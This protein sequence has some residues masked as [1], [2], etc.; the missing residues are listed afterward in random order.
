MHSRW[1]I[2]WRSQISRLNQSQTKHIKTKTK[3][4]TKSVMWPMAYSDIFC[5]KMHKHMLENKNKFLVV[6]VSHKSQ[7]CSKKA[8]GLQ[9]RLK[10]PQKPIS[11]PR[12]HNTIWHNI[13]VNNKG[14]VIFPP[15][16]PHF[17]IDVQFCIWGRFKTFLYS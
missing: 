2:L 16:A 4:I 11:A 15:W 3:N 6:S 14:P 7:S 8:K 13:L 5:M 1:H 9:N 12:I 10:V 17:T